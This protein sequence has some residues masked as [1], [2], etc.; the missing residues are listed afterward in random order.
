[1]RATALVPVLAAVWLAASTTAAAANAS[2][3]V[4]RFKRNGETV[5]ELD[6]A[7]I[8]SACTPTRIQVD[9]P[10]YGRPKDFLACPLRSV[11]VLGFG[12]SVT[13]MGDQNF[14]LRALDGYTRPAAG[15]RL[16]EAGGYLAIADAERDDGSWEPIDRRQ[17]DPGPF[18]MIWSR[19]GQNDTNRYP[20]PFQLASIEIAAFDSEYP[21]TL[22]RG[23]PSEDPAWSGFAIFRSECV[24]CHAV[25]GEG[26]KIGPD[27]NVPRSIVEYRP[28]DQIKAF[29][30]DP[31]S[32]R[33]TT[34]PAHRH[35]TDGQLDAIVAYFEAMKTRKRDPGP[36]PVAH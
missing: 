23:V 12:E 15:A 29:V 36:G 20:W 2:D 30:R 35:L 25:N 3:G 18:Y 31:Q 7:A 10:Y 32:F 33:Y 16:L 11:L 1:M 4:L 13:Q 24:A 19:P 6:R 21:H 27:L 28:A 22:P 8:E 5:A 34:M 9:D 26:G 14:F 17:L